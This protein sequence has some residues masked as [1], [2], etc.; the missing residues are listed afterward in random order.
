M[1]SVVMN[2]T[3][4][5]TTGTATFGDLVCDMYLR[6]GKPAIALVKHRDRNEGPYFMCGP[7]AYHNTRN[8]NSEALL[9][10]NGEEGWFA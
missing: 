2:S 5:E 9:V 8:R 10:Q 3:C 1:I 6:C 7:C 4:E